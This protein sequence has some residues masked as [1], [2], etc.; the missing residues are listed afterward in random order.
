MT[1]AF[2][3]EDIKNEMANS[4]FKSEFNKPSSLRPARKELLLYK[5]YRWVLQSF[6][7]MAAFYNAMNMQV[8]CEKAYV[9]YVQIVESFFTSDSL[10]TSNAYF[11]VGVY[12]FEQN[13]T[14]KSIACLRKALAIREV[15]FGPMHISCSD[16]LL[17]LGILYK[18]R[19]LTDLAR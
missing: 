2:S 13:M 10:E 5:E 9:R 17:N 11:L 12:Y 19:G 14:H 4:C 16:C 1:K 6:G 3:V 18:L 7:L 15:K 8:Q